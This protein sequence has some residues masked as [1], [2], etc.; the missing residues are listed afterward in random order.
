[1]K[2]LVAA[3]GALCAL[4]LPRTAQAEESE[5]AETR[6]ED[7]LASGFIPA[8]RWGHIAVER[9]NEDGSTFSEGGYSIAFDTTAHYI[10]P[11]DRFGVGVNAGLFMNGASSETF[12]YDYL[13]WEIGPVVEVGVFERLFL[14]ARVNYLSASDVE[15]QDVTG[16]R[17]GGGATIVAWRVAEADMALQLDVTKTSA[18]THF[19]SGERNLDVF[20][21]SGGLL[22]T[23][24]AV[25]PED[26]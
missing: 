26:L 3:A 15:S 7:R 6:A 8:F 19:A 11:G 13:G 24:S 4:A 14:H 21:I 1:M 18:K 16:F 10:L 5:P 9:E 2:R 12:A 25:D 23:F 17:Y 20:T 22:F